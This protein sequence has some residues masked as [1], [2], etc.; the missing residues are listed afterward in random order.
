VSTLPRGSDQLTAERFGQGATLSK[1]DPQRIVDM[2]RSHEAKTV[3]W[4]ILGQPAPDGAVDVGV[5]SLGG[6][7]QG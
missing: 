6:V 3:N 4:W 5:A 7:V 1:D 2:A